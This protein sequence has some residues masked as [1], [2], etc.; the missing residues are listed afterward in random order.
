MAEVLGGRSIGG[1]EDG[2]DV[3]SEAEGSETSA[4]AFEGEGGEFCRA[5]RK[6][7]PALAG[8]LVGPFKPEVPEPVL[9]AGLGIHD[10]ESLTPEIG[11][12]ALV[13]KTSKE[14]LIDRN[15]DFRRQR[16]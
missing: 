2:Q 4:E 16:G 7:G 5:V 13:R 3:F 15:F 10:A 12:E 1:G 11:R 14:L 9:A 8:D 6:P